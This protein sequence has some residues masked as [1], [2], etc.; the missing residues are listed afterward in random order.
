MAYQKMNK[1]KKTEGLAKKLPALQQNFNAYPNPLL[2][3]KLP[4][5]H[6]FLL[7]NRPKIL[8]KPS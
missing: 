1:P 7:K 4:C 8:C 5:I 2:F 3:F 6:P